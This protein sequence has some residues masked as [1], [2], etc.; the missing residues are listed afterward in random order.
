LTRPFEIGPKL[1]VL[2][3]CQ[4]SRN[5]F[6]PLSIEVVDI[7]P[8]D[9]LAFLCGRIG[10]CDIEHPVLHEVVIGVAA[11][12][13]SP[14]RKPDVAVRHQSTDPVIRWGGGMNLF[15]AFFKIPGRLRLRPAETQPQDDKR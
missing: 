1:L 2:S 11:V 10:A 3:F 12:C 15:D 8:I 4:F 7:F 13:P 6:S 5:S 9:L 14:A